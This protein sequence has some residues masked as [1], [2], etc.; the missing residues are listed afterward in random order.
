V[1]SVRQ[2]S[3]GSFTNL[4]T[5][6][7]IGGV[8]SF[9]SISLTLDAAGWSLVAVDTKG[10]EYTNSTA[11]SGNYVGTY[12][13][14][15]TPESWGSHFYLGMDAVETT[16]AEGRYTTLTVG[17]IAVVPEPKTAA[18]AVIFLAAAAVCSKPFRSLAGRF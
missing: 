10:H 1:M 13:T 18:L 12:K 14:A 8:Y 16:G 3:S 15:L 17:Q 6:S 9:S 11:A 4:A 7:I 5:W 2:L